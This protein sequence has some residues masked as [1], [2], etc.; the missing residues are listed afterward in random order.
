MIPSFDRFDHFIDQT[1]EVLS[2]DS[3]SIDNL[4]LKKV[5]FFIFRDVIFEKFVDCSHIM[6]KLGKDYSE[7]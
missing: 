3:Y 6:Q 1:F 5:N 7:E 2:F 4:A